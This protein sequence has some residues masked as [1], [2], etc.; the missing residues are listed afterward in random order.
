MRRIFFF[1]SPHFISKWYL[2]SDIK[3]INKKYFFSG[4]LLDVGCGDKPYKDL[5]TNVQSYLGIDFKN[6]SKNREYVGERPDLY[7]NK[8]YIKTHMLPFNTNS[9]DTVVSFQVLE[10]HIQPQKLISEIIRVCKK[11]GYILISAPLIWSLHELPN[12]YTR[13]TEYGIRELI[14]GKN[15]KI[16]FIKSQGSIFS[17]IIS[18]LVDYLIEIAQTNRLFYLL[19][20]LIYPFFLL[21]SY[22]TLLLDK[23]FKSKYIFNNY[24]LLVRKL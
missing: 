1:F 22:S 17:T 10:H 16:L 21:L 18:L 15:C 9:F 24:I 14:T 19:A 23:I 5:F 2:Y 3:N 6:F 11:G 13:F 20:L 7:F 4:K 12:D 8:N